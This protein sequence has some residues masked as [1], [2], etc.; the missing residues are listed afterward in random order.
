MMVPKHLESL[1]RGF[2][3]ESA[4][5]V[6]PGRIASYALAGMGFLGAGAIIV[7]RNIVRG[8]TTAAG[9]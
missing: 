2:R 3:M 5:R 1:Q 9:M 6:D 8:L 4:V 7:G